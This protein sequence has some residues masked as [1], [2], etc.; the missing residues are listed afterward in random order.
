MRRICVILSFVALCAATL[1]PATARPVATHHRTEA[2]EKTPPALT[3]DMADPPGRGRSDARIAFRPPLGV[4]YT[5][6][7]TPVTFR[8]HASQDRTYRV[9]LPDG[10]HRWRSLLLGAPPLSA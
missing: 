10:S 6:F 7:E 8:S 4:R 1:T 3:A 2:S 9:V 5:E